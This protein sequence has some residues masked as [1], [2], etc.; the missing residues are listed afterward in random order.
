MADR[1]IRI[2]ISAAEPSAD[3]HCANLIK[4]VNSAAAETGS[5]IEKVEWVGIGGDNMARAGCDLIENPSGRAVMIYNAF[6]HVKY[7]LGLIKRAKETI[8]AGAFDLVIVCD[9]PAFN[10]HIAKAARANGVA[11]FFYVA[12]QLWAWAPWRVRKLRRLCDKLACILPFEKE[13]FARRGIDA[14]FVGNPLFEEAGIDISESFRD[15]S[16]FDNRY[17]KA[18]FFPGSRKAE[19]NKLWPDMQKIAVR[20]RN[21]WPGMT[22]Y[23]SA[24]DDEK[25]EMLREMQTPDIEF[26]YSVGKVGPTARKADIAFVTSGSATLQVAAAGCPMIIMYQSSRFLWQIAGQW[27]VRTRFLSLVNILAGRELVPEFMPYFNSI[28][29]ILETAYRMLGNKNRMTKTGNELVR[30]VEPMTRGSAS[31]KTADIVL[32]MLQK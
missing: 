9:S 30:L 16:G 19:I 20:L 11:A 12:P 17:A 14:A 15:Y 25:L 24:C 28:E 18:A 2:F 3:I 26:H 7:F 22:F 27:L 1:K 10:F 29:P 6:A 23:V 5:G 8:S 31:K 13:W 4:A 32:N 21:R